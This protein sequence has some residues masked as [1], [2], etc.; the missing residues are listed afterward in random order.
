MSCFDLSTSCQNGVV[1]PALY[2]LHYTTRPAPWERDGPVSHTVLSAALL[3]SQSDWRG[4]AL[5]WAPHIEILIMIA[6][7]RAVY[8]LYTRLNIT[9]SAFQP[10]P[11]QPFIRASLPF[12]ATQPG[13]E[14]RGRGH[15]EAHLK[16]GIVDMYMAGNQ[17]GRWSD[18]KDQ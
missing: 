15:R 14:T 17:S 3:L 10:P 2:I 12:R 16:L 11:G 4:P 9:F 6:A 13:A 5:C 1:Y 8:T 18:N 7:P